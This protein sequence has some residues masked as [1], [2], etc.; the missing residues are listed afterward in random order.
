MH[1]L[2]QLRHRL[3]CKVLVL[4]VGVVLSLQL[5]CPLLNLDGLSEIRPE[6]VTRQRENLKINH[7]DSIPVGTC[8]IPVS[9]LDGHRSEGIIDGKSG[10]RKT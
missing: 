1:D 2:R 10:E 3:T 8:R 4:I 7:R 6:S 9:Q 5:G